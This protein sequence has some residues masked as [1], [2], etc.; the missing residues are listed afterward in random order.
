MKYTHWQGLNCSATVKGEWWGGRQS[1]CVGL[2]CIG[3]KPVCTLVQIALDDMISGQGLHCRP[4]GEGQVGS[5]AVPAGIAESFFA[6]LEW[7]V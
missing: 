7:T 4:M 2:H 5:M 1:W 3:S 6:V